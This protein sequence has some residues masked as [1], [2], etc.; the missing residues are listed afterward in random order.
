MVSLPLIERAR[1]DGLS[2]LLTGMA[3]RTTE[4]RLYTIAP[5]PP[6]TLIPTRALLPGEQ[7]RFHFDMT[8]CIGC[9]CCVCGLQ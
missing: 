4:D 6:E 1:E 5:M 9:K 3:T 7:Y 8:Q 2:F